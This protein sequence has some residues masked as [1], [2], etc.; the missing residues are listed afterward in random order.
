MDLLALIC[1]ITGAYLIDSGVVN[2]APLGTF[3]TVLRNPGASR[4]ALKD[5]RGTGFLPQ[6]S[7]AVSFSGVNG[8]AQ[9]IVNSPGIAAAIAFATAQIGKPYRFGATGPAAFDCSGLVQASWKAGGYNLLRTSQLMAADPRLKTVSQAALQPGDLVYP[10]LGHVQ[11]YVGNG[12]VIEAANP[13]VP[14]RQVAL[15]GFFTANRVP[16]PAAPNNTVTGQPNTVSGA[17]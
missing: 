8:S 12:Q 15:W 7:P 9:G 10:D 4:T 5:S 2:R 17:P 6:T 11:L 1:V 3:M 14:I 16:S 13:S